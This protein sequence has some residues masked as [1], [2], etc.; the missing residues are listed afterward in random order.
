MSSYDCTPVRWRLAV[1]LEDALSG[2]ED[3][4]SGRDSRG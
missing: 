2:L 3:A 1:R 4:L